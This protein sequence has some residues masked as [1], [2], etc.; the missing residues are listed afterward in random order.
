MGGIIST[1][2]SAAGALSVYER[3]FSTI[4]NNISNA[5]TPGF[6]DQNLALSAMSFDPATGAGGGVMSHGL[7]SS[8]SEFLE[9]NVRSQQ[10][11][12]GSSQ[13][14]ASD[15]GQ[16]EPLFNPNSTDGVAS[17]L[18]G[19]F[20]SFSALSVS[21]NDP[22]AEQAVITA[23]GQVARSFNQAAAGIAQ[24]SSG[25]ESQT[26]STVA[27][28]NQIAGQ[29]ASLN[30]QYQNDAASTGDAGLDAQMHSDLEN[31]SQ[32]ANFST[33]KS[34]DGSYNVFLGGQTPLVL[35]NQQFQISAGFSSGQTQILDS[36]SI[37]VTSQITGGSLGGMLQDNNTTLPGYTSQLNTLAQT[38]ADQVNGQ[39]AQGLDQSGA[40]PT[41][42]LFSYDQ[43]NDA[44]STLT[45]TPGFTPD[46]IAAASAGAAG[47]NGNAVAVANL[48]NAAVVNGVTFTQAFGNLSS[49]VGSD[50]AAAQQNQ[51]GDQDLLTQAQ[52][53]RQQVSGVNLNAEAAK[54]LQFQQSY[55]AVGQMVTVLNSLT[56][57]ILNL[58]PP[59]TSS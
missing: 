31:L 45:V 38:F 56:Q 25:I 48:A 51:T 3:E 53:Q 27:Q 34:G 21:P 5:N 29:I 23:A 37:D 57:T 11:L 6:A 22:N 17:S 26:S 15:L 55:Q 7:L 16:V 42:N 1:L 13:Q 35:G 40:A 58:L 30:Q 10:T 4:Q 50:V 18:S 36:Q 39:L 43:A 20:N 52:Q 44:A 46:Q 49:Q 24:T 12:L 9:Q 14:T 8:R 54:L 59:G 47:G 32:L 2:T 41:T 28:I 19:F 33:I